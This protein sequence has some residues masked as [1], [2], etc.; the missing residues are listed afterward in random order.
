MASHIKNEELIIWESKFP[1]FGEHCYRHRQLMY[2]VEEM[3]NEYQMAENNESNIREHFNNV[4]RSFMDDVMTE[5][6]EFRG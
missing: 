6:A 5:A 1:N 3:L 4:V 2:Q